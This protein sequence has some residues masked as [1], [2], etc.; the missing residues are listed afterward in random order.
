MG[1][2][3]T[4]ILTTFRRPNLLRR[5]IRSV[6]DQWHRDFCLVV[7]DN[8][9]KD[10]TVAVVNE[11]RSSDQRIHLFQRQHN[12]PPYDNV[13]D[14]IARVKTPFFTICADDDFLFPCHLAT[15][16]PPLSA[17][18][19]L[20]YV[21]GS[22]LYVT[23]EGD[24]HN[25]CPGDWP[26]GR[27]NAGEA[28]L[29]TVRHGHVAWQAALF[30]TDLV[31]GVGGGPA[32]SVGLIGDV[33]FLLRLGLRHPVYACPEIVAVH[34]CHPQQGGARYNLGQAGGFA[35][36]YRRLSA[37]ALADTSQ[38][39]EF[40]KIL[41]HWLVQ[42]MCSL[43]VSPSS[44]P[45]SVALL[46]RASWHLLT[47]LQSTGAAVR[48]FQS[49]FLSFVSCSAARYPIQ[50]QAALEAAWLARQGVNHIRPPRMAS[51]AA[52]DTQRLAAC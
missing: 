3:I 5:A 44:P 4:V 9:S 45:P 6:L 40:R 25:F 42:F 28:A 16:H 2:E 33:D 38:Q 49:A 19:E 43:T 18:P 22:F 48:F 30:R 36:M 15:L 52:A 26:A 47:D 41:R 12:I 23:L 51:H 27:N 11:F 1:C 34:S 39:E 31:R 46:A 50:R 17:D 20:A 21:F 37:I 35:R 29:N 13:S 8:G 14:A 32:K 7:Y 24:I 10:S